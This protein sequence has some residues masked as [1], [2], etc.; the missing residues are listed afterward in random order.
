M[1]DPNYDQLLESA[2]VLSPNL[3]SMLVEQLVASLDDECQ[4]EVDSAWGEEVERRL[5]EVESG[6]VSTES[7][8]AIINRLR[9]RSR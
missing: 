5:M 8:E 3:R 2:L 9:S 7:S 1:I 6:Q 4:A